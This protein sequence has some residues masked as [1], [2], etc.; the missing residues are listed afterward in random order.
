MTWPSPEI[1]KIEAI[2]ARDPRYAV[3]AYEFTRAAVT[4]AS[5]VLY[6]RGTHVS[7]QEL[8][9]AIRRLA[10]DR[11]GLLTED[12]FRSWGVTK[13]DDFGEIVFNLVEAEVLSKTP[14]DSREDFRDVYSFAEVFGAADYWDEVVSAVG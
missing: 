12:V 8:L 5:R 7:G 6:A 14:E 10:L 4:Y 2:I 13:T 9:E 11:F 3:G 1:R